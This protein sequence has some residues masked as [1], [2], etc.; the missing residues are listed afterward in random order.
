V[1]FTVQRDKLLRALV[2]VERVTAKNATLPILNNL[3][4]AAERGTLRVSA[5]NLEVGVSVDISA[6]VESEGTLAVPARILT[7]LVK[8][9]TGE[10]VTCTAKQSTL[11]VTSGGNRSSLL[12]FDASEY[13]IIPTVKGGVS[14]TITA[15]I[16]TDALLS[17]VDSIAT[18]D[19]RPELSGAYLKIGN[20][21]FIAAATDSFRL[22]ERRVAF[23]QKQ[24]ATIIVPRQTIAELLR[25]L[26]G[27]SSEVEIHIA[28]NQLSLKSDGYTV[29]SRLI[30]GKYP[31]YHK[32]I[33]ERS[34]S[35]VLLRHSDLEQAIKVA[36]LFTSSISDVKLISTER[37]LTV[38]AKNA[39]KGEGEA[40]IEANL[41][42]EPFEISMNYHY[43]LDGLRVLRA[44]HVILEFTGKGSPFMLRP[45]DP[46]GSLVYIIM[47]LR[48]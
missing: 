5:T 44:E 25:V 21:E 14:F 36:A 42:G 35:K 17:I 6:K 41:K 23:T 40:T 4:F 46:K 31:D 24:E 15:S 22:A 30:D 19:A 7:E 43:L 16:L 2:A 1:K 13:P 34:L 32:V 33:P 47:P 48:G 38:S 8:A 29:V 18:S 37:A 45:E 12:C 11:T 39:G 9:A 3:L 27:V 28:E 10:V 20:K 26:D